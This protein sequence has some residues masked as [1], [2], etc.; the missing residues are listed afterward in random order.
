MNEVRRIS[1]NQLVKSVT[2]I[3]NSA[4]VARTTLT[5][6]LGTPSHTRTLD[7]RSNFFITASKSIGSAGSVATFFLNKFIDTSYYTT[8]RL[9]RISSQPKKSLLR[10]FR[11]YVNAFFCEIFSSTCVEWNCHTACCIFNAELCTFSIFSCNGINV[12]KDSCC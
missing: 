5:R 7:S 1:S 2:Y 9:R 8:K 12:I 11:F 4:N 3:Q 6:I 10:L